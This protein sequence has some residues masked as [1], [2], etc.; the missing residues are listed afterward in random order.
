MK[1]HSLLIFICFFFCC[2]AHV[3]ARWPRAGRSI[4]VIRRQ[5]DQ[6]PAGG[7]Q[8]QGA[9]EKQ[10]AAEPEQP[11]NKPEQPA[12]KPEQPA[13]KPEQP[14][15][16]PEQPA[17]KP[18]QPATKPEQ[19]AAKPQSDQ[20][21]QQQQEQQDEAAGARQPTSIKRPEPQPTPKT[22][23]ADRER[24]AEQANGGDTGAQNR[25]SQARQDQNVPAKTQQQVQ[26]Q[27]TQ[28]RNQAGL[29]NSQ[30]GQ[31]QGQR[32]QAQNPQ[33]RP[34]KAAPAAD[35][36]TKAGPGQGRQ[37]QNPEDQ[38]ARSQAQNEQDRQTRVPP[39]QN[40]PS[41]T[42]ESLSE[43]TRGSS[44][45]GQ[46]QQSELR[47]GQGERTL[48][49]DAGGRQT[50]TQLGQG[51]RSQTRQAQ[52]ER[53]QV[54]SADAQ[55]T[56]AK[57]AE[58]QE[59]QTRLGDNRQ[60]QLRKAQGDQ[61]QSEQ[62]LGRQ[63]QTQGVDGLI[64]RTRDLGATKSSPNLAEETGSG[65]QIQGQRTQ[66]GARGDS[67]LG[68]AEGRETQ[69]AQSRPSKV[70]G[71]QSTDEGAGLHTQG[72]DRNLAD[73]SQ[74]LSGL[75][76][77][78]GSA[79]LPRESDDSQNQILGGSSGVGTNP[80]NSLANALGDTRA[81]GSAQ[82]IPSGGDRSLEA[83][84]ALET[85]TQL[86]SN[87]LRPNIFLQQTP[88]SGGFGGD[89][90][91]TNGAGQ[92]STPVGNGGSTGASGPANTGSPLPQ[93]G[94]CGGT[95]NGGASGSCPEGNQCVCKDSSK[96]KH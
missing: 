59:T 17:T 80:T 92:L 27:Q 39:G 11:A 14:A 30:G 50:Q 25:Q 24:K 33:G 70:L 76:D 41:R 66:S 60:S 46:N 57:L 49:E 54:R 74:R 35:Q 86:K 58:G 73:Q 32:S 64:T 36:R 88:S 10:P 63:T 48:A 77:N 69:G 83:F 95:Y 62:G 28:Q 84:D 23:E 56:K 89:F 68:N 53:T 82:I 3:A 72:A 93:Y 94:Q 96:S 20:A 79:R 87:G 67:T 65:E 31:E 16:K 71:Q 5:A 91:S 1:I 55:E 45:Q 19:P 34:T 22:F 85:G 12:T 21:A 51:G 26:P 52:G 15:T 40:R 61:T 43:Q 2:E 47:E 37:T 13:T 29:D 75:P 7:S 4:N 42:Q 18:E 81:T 78:T 9:Q 44:D 6:K 90:G 8:P 38:G